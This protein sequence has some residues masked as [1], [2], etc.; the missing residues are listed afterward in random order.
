MPEFRFM[1]ARLKK[2]PLRK[3]RGSFFCLPVPTRVVSAPYSQ[4][5]V[6]SYTRSSVM[7]APASV[8][9]HHWWAI[10]IPETEPS[11]DESIVF[12]ERVLTRFCAASA[13]NLGAG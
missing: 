10:V 8:R 12:L 13:K 1:P 4:L 2:W 9:Q 7:G 3:K 5:K 11:A 6:D